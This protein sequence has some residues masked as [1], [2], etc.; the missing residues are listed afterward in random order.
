MPAAW[1]TSRAHPSLCPRGA[2]PNAA[3]ET[4]PLHPSRRAV[5]LDWRLRELEGLRAERRRLSFSTAEADAYLRAVEEV[6]GTAPV[7]AG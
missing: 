1:P 2:W 5:Q 3:A 6:A 7:G 4:E